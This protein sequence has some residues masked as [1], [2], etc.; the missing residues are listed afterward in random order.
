MDQVRTL[1]AALF[2]RGP[3]TV[4]VTSAELADSAEGGIDTLAVERSRAFRVTTPRVPISPNGTGDLFAALYAAA[5]VGGKDTPEALAH[6]ASGIF[7][8]LERTAKAGTE[9]MR[10]VESAAELVRPP[11]RFEAVAIGL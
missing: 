7:A 4:V 1:A 9:E 10:I 2:A 3:K 5:I 11:R 6:A 8:V